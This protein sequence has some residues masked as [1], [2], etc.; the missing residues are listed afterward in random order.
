MTHLIFFFRSD[1]Y[2]GGAYT[3][4]GYQMPSKMETKTAFGGN[5]F[6]F[7]SQSGKYASNA[8]PPVNGY[9]RNYCVSSIFI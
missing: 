2:R 1:Q 5:S 8:Q 6:P 7:M 9:N 4:G 3:P